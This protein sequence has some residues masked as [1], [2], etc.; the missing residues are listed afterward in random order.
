MHAV[1]VA[2]NIAEGRS[3]EAQ[4]MLESTIVQQVKQATGFVSGTWLRT[5]DGKFG[6]SLVLFDSKE[7]AEESAKTVEA[8][9]EG[10]VSVVNVAV[11]EVVAQA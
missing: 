10:P 2:V 4:A 6:Y 7:H 9:P 5:P 3:A 11:Y 1:A 8:A